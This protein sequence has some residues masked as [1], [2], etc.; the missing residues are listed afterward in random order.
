MAQSHLAERYI[1]VEGYAPYTYR[2]KVSIKR[3]RLE[4]RGPFVNRHIYSPEI[5]LKN[6]SWSTLSSKEMSYTEAKDAIANDYTIKLSK[7]ALSI[8]ETA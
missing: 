7:E 4:Y 6:R 3:V 1:F 2:I 8:K 5:Q